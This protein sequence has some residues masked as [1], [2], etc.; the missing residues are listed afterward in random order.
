MTF[1][2]GDFVSKK[3]GS[4]WRGR[5]VGNYGTVLTDAGYVVESWFEPGSVQNY[6]EAAL[7]PWRPPAG[8]ASALLEAVKAFLA[9]APDNERAVANLRRAAATAMKGE[10]AK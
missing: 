2:I 1:Y 4:K 10:T 3:H 8:D 6:P 9:T 5:V 7:E